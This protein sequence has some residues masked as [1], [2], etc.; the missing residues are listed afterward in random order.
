M[1]RA[2]WPIA[3]PHRGCPGARDRV[4]LA[5]QAS[6]ILIIVL[7]EAVE[8]AG[9]P[10]PLRSREIAPITLFVIPMLYVVRGFRPAAAAETAAWTV[11]LVALDIGRAAGIG[12]L[13]GWL[14]GRSYRHHRH[15]RRLSCAARDAHPSSGRGGAGG[16][17]RYRA[18][19]ERSQTPTFVVNADGRIREANA[20]AGALFAGSRQAVGGDA[21]ADM[22]GGAAARQLLAGKP[23][24]ALLQTT[25]DGDERVLRPYCTA[26]VDADG[27][28][29]WQIVLHDITEERWQRRRMDAYAASVLRGQEEERRRIAHELHDEPVQELMHICRRLDSVSQ[30]VA[31]PSETIAA[32]EQT[33]QLTERIAQSLRDLARGLRPPSLDDLGLVASLRQ[34][35][36]KFEARTGIVATFDFLGGGASPGA[37][38]RAWPLSYR[39]GGA[40]QR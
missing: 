38:R 29:L 33:R 12:A 16:P 2:A 25:A 11:A 7:Y 13:G 31:L 36:A 32:L 4:I 39:P 8:I 34:L 15:L 10:W 26:V 1:S 18:L 5:A 27:D 24:A 21:L 22:F 40:T 37:R 17:A 19:F 20:A 28:A 6:A 30:R 14:A 9:I 35:F 3:L 23:P